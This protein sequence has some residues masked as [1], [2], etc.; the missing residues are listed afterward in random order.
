MTEEPSEEID[1][2][3]IVRAAFETLVFAPIGLGAKFV[4]DA[5]GAV[6]RVRQELS[7]A[8]FIGRLTVEQGTARIRQAAAQTHDEPVLRNDAAEVV[9]TDS[10]G[11]LPID[12]Y[13]EMPAI[14]IVAVLETL[15]ATQR[16]VVAAHES[17]N[18]GRRTVLGKIAQ[19]NA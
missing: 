9:S 13:D 12:G 3:V 5:P 15:T 7:N 11:A 6:R 18:R 4:D 1:P 19:L 16:D 2:A 17:A 14:E 8:R 10:D